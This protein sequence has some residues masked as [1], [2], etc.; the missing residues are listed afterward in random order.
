MPPSNRLLLIQTNHNKGRDPYTLPSVAMSHPALGFPKDQLSTLLKQ[1]A[2]PKPLEFYRTFQ[3]LIEF[4]ILTFNF[5]GPFIDDKDDT[6][7]KNLK[8]KKHHLINILIII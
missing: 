6:K 8:S 7:K 1:F 5:D 2:D 4:G 3:S